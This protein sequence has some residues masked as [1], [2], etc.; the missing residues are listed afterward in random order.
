MFP[1][2]IKGIGY[3]VYQMK[4]I[5][6]RDKIIRKF[7]TKKKEKAGMAPKKSLG[8]QRYSGQRFSGEGGGAKGLLQQR[9]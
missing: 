3:T 1:K 4:K 9:Y 2:N 5:G 8:R 6:S 7:G